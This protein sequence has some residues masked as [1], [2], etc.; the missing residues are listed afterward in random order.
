MKALVL[1]WSATGNTEK[2]AQEI[3][4][5]LRNTG[6]KTDFYKIPAGEDTEIMDYDLVF[7]GCPSYQ[8]MPP[9]PVVK[10]IKG[11]MKA[12]NERGIIVPGAPTLPGKYA[13]TFCTYSGPHTG[14]DEAIPVGKY[15][16]QFFAHL[17]FTVKDEWY[18]VGE[19]HNNVVMSTK[20]RLGDITGRPNEQ[21]L[22]RVRDN[23]KQL[24]SSV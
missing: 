7:F 20:G 3:E 2:I 11:R 24:L 19:F 6:V 4:A 14:V 15:L 16:G 12:Y 17:G 21:D 8:F 23:V 9:D 1:Y 10:Y 5:S 22:T 18:F 13:V